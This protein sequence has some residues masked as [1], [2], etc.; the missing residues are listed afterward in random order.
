MERSRVFG[1]KCGEL[2]ASFDQ[3]LCVWKTSQ[4]CLPWGSEKY[5]AAW[6]RS[7]MMRS[8]KLY[9]LHNAEHPI[10]ETEYSLLP[11]PL[12]T[13]VDK[14]GTGGLLRLITYP[15]G[16]KR[17]SI[18]DYRNFHSNL[19]TPTK[20]FHQEYGSPSEWKRKDPTLITYFIQPDLAI[21]KRPRLQP[22]FVEW[23]MG[24][25]IGWLNLERWEIVSYLN[26]QNGL[27]EE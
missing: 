14:H 10:E 27:E 11:T 13:D 2:L 20:H 16:Q 18:G 17:Y 6:P 8:G 26:A 1:G 7:G 23:M 25:P 22:Q 3:E 24:Y 21:G 5:S 19:P 15:A 4:G 9:R 12:A